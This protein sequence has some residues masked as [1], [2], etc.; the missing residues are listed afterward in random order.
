ML[1]HV[2]AHTYTHP[3]LGDKESSPES[4]LRDLQPW[5]VHTP[6]SQ[7][8]PLHSESLHSPLSLYTK[9]M[10]G[11][12]GSENPNRY[13]NLW[14]S[15]PVDIMVQ[16][17]E[18]SHPSV[19]RV[20]HSLIQLNGSSLVETVNVKST[21]IES[22]LYCVLVA[23]WC[24]TLCNPRDYSQLG[25]SVHGILQARI[26]QWVAMPFSRGSS[27][28]RDWTWVSCIA[29]GL[30]TIWE[31]HLWESSSRHRVYIK[32]TLKQLNMNWHGMCPRIQY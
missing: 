24:P 26:L 9:G 15:N 22:G 12:I 32:S 10:D 30:F 17:N 29:G 25:S 1:T 21:D 11:E 4:K 27:W 19:L 18:Y 28:P 14:S 6:V 3:Q 13:Q 2:C 20:L 7:C 5:T 16:Y 31:G 23:Q 8:P